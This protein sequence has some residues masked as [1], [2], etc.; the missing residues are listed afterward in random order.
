MWVFKI[1]AQLLQTLCDPMEHSPPGSSVHGIFPARILK[2]VSMPS[3]RGSS[4]P[5]DQTHISCNSCRS[6]S[7]YLLSI[8]EAPT[9]TCAALCLVAQSPCDPMDCSPPGSSVH[10]ILQARILEWVAIPFSRGSSWP[11]SPTLQVDSLPAEPSGKPKNT[12]VCSLPLLLGIFPT[13]ES[14]WGSP[15]LQVDSLPA[16]L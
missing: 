8:R 11:R 1:C 2:W 12:G 4:W 6:R 15:V 3:S 13:R 16:E 9:S 14:N 10:G 7:I 5:R